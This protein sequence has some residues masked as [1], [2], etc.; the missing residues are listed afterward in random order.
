MLGV[1]GTKTGNTHIYKPTSK[2]TGKSMD[3]FKTDL[4]LFRAC[5][6]IANECLYIDE[7]VYS[8]CQ[9][10]INILEGALHQSTR[11]KNLPE[12]DEVE[13]HHG[14]LNCLGGSNKDKFW[15]P[16]KVHY[17]IHLLNF[18]VFRDTQ[19]ASAVGSFVMRFDKGSD[20]NALLYEWVADDLITAQ[21]HTSYFGDSECSRYADMM[22]EKGKLGGYKGYL[23]L[24]K[25]LGGIEN[26]KKHMATISR[27]G[28]LALH[29]KLVAEYG[30]EG[31]SKIRAEWGRKAQE[32][33]VAK[34][35]EEGARTI[36]AEWGRK[37]FENLVAKHGE[38]GARKIKRMNGRLRET[39]NTDFPN[40]PVGIV[41]DERDY[42]IFMKY[43]SRLKWWKRTRGN[44]DSPE[45]Q[46]LLQMRKPYNAGY[47]RWLKKYSAELKRKKAGPKAVSK[48]SATKPA[49]VTKASMKLPAKKQARP[50]AGVT[51]ASMKSPPAVISAVTDHKT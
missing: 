51:K 1:L 22:A 21:I 25:K 24:V 49:G 45:C 17:Q 12:E 36:R 39:V 6:E 28:A 29:R 44:M 31:A 42:R 32:N 19:H 27:K 26:F 50:K 40:V 48:T 11:P 2:S 34:H 38:E 16:K 41:G 5:T 30:E 37:S 13:G 9:Q 23:A 35:G 20:Y 14:I 47:R 3:E 7:F 18:A 15:L 4:D 10:I 43:S 33:L 8:C 46:Q